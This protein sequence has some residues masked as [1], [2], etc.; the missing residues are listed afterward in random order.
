[1]KVMERIIQ[2]LPPEKLDAFKEFQRKLDAPSARLGFPPL[3]WYTSFFTAEQSF[4]LVCE[5]EW[6]S[7]AALEAT[8]AKADAD[9]EYTSQTASW[10]SVG[11]SH[12]EE[13]WLVGL[14]Y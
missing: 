9:P 8:Y 12:R 11:K 10:P 4:T 13:L 5:R 7:M 6:P 2:E 14:G 1:M 3:R